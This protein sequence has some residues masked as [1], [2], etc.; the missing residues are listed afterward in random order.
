MAYS[1]DGKQI[2]SVAE[3]DTIRVWDAE[4]GKLLRTTEAKVNFRDLEALRMDGKVV[5][6]LSKGIIYSVDP[7]AGKM[8]RKVVLDAEGLPQWGSFSPDGTRLAYGVDAYGRIHVHDAATG[9]EQSRHQLANFHFARWLAFTPDGK[10]LAVYLSAKTPGLRFLD[11]AT[12]QAMADPGLPPSPSFWFA[13]DG[14]CLLD[15]SL[16][17]RQTGKR[18]ATLQLEKNARPFASVAFS[19]DSRHVAI[20]GWSDVALYDTGTG[21]EL[22]RFPTGP[23]AAWNLDFPAVPTGP[24]QR[25][26]AFSPDGRRLLVGN[27]DGQISQWE[28]A[29][30][31]P[32][33][34]ADPFTGTLRV[35]R[36]IDGKHLLVQ[37]DGLVLYDRNTGKLTR[38]YPWQGEAN[39]R[40]VV[41]LSPD[42]KI[43]TCPGKAGTIDLR[44][45]QT[46]K[47]IRTL[48]GDPNMTLLVAFAPDGRRLYSSGG[49][50][51]MI[52]AWD[53][54]DGKQLHEIEGRS[55]RYMGSHA[56]IPYEYI[57]VSPDSRRFATAASDTDGTGKYWLRVWEADSGKLVSQLAFKKSL[58]RHFAFAPAGGLLVVEDD[59]WASKDAALNLIEPATAK[60]RWRVE[61]KNTHVASIAFSGDGQTLAVGGD[62]GSLVLYE[63]ATGRRRHA[64][65]GHTRAVDGLAFTPDGKL[66]AASSADAPVYLWDVYGT[67]DRERVVVA[68]WTAEEEPRLWQNLASVDAELPFATIRRLIQH[69]QAAVAFLKERLRPVDANLEKQF[70]KLLRELDGDDFETRQKADTELKQRAGEF[71]LQLHT[72]LGQNPSLEVKRRLEGIVATVDPASPELLRRSRA[73]EVLEQIATPEAK[74][75]R[76]TLGARSLTAADRKLLDG[77][78]EQ[79]L[80][81]PRGA[82]RVQLSASRTAVDGSTYVD[83]RV[84]WHVAAK[85]RVFFTDGASIP[86]PPAQAMTN[87]D[88]FAAC[89]ARLAEKLLDP[90][91]PKFDENYDPAEPRGDLVLAAWLHR[92]GGDDLAAPCSARMRGGLS[93]RK[94]P[95]GRAAQRAGRGGLL[96]AGLQ[97]RSPRRRRGACTWRT[98]VQTL[99]GGGGQSGRLEFAVREHCRRGPPAPQGKGHLRHAGDERLAGGVQRLGPKPQARIPHRCA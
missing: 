93:P 44:D 30:G 1:A 76:K 26:L 95:G 59:A 24:D 54:A 84:G 55:G 23:D 15:G 60:Q 80:F 36:F 78:F 6:A 65:K 70:Q 18:L 32:L 10:Q 74:Q 33:T 99:R 11:P 34:C 66:L 49:M 7:F 53:V 46:G 2:I 45:A 8:L 56:V 73:M 94:E 41:Q 61:L 51:A 82:Q 43:L 71:A 48:A 63:P 40:S 62:D 81:D 85:G 31:K 12:G 58:A 39:A 25:P 92:L 42:G 28:V 90:D 75:L 17:D 77:L 68:P 13:P 47:P 57:A 67:H 69:P 64:F 50:F 9:K 86:A 35:R 52:R 16:W 83:R 5:D 14:R 20:P 37:T 87:V 38:R 96:W 88:F 91:D 72:A 89:K 3:D 19:A 27:R 79:F 97:I 4:T 22:R 98:I 21:K 29:T